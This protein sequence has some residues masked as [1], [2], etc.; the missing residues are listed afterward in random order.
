VSGEEGPFERTAGGDGTCDNILDEIA[1]GTR[2][3]HEFS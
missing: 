1:T 2:H 3:G